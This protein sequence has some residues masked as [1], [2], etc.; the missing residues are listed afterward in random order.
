M[1]TTVKE[2]GDSLGERVEVGVDL[3]QAESRIKEAATRL[4]KEMKVQEPREGKVP[5]EMVLQ[6]AR[7]CS[8]RPCSWL[9]DGNERAMIE[10]GISPVGDPKLDLD[11]LPGEGEPL[12]FAIEVNVLPDAKLKSTR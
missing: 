1:E 11:A 4:G 2:L 7:P 3:D 5:P 6:D 8:A 9:G 10:T 12:K